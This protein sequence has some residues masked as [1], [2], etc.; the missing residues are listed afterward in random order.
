[1]KKLYLN[2][3]VIFL[4]FFALSCANKSQESLSSNQWHRVIELNLPAPSDA[5]LISKGMSSG[6]LLITPH[7][8]S[9]RSNQ[10]YYKIYKSL[11]KQEYKNSIPV[12]YNERVEH[13]IDLFRYRHHEQFSK[14][15]NRSQKYLPELTRLLE[16]Q[17]MPT[18]LAYLPLIESGY[19]PRARSPKNAV[20]LW[21]FIKSTGKIYDLR[22]DSW[23]DERKDIYKST[24]AATNYLKDLHDQFGSWEL[25]LAAYNCGELRVEDTINL[26][27]SND[28][29]HIASSLPRE[30]RNYVPKFIAA[31]IIAKNPNKYG[32]SRI[33]FEEPKEIIKVTVP[34]QKYL[35][36]IAKVIDYKP[37]ELKVLNLSLINGFTP[38]REYYDIYIPAEYKDEIASKSIEIAALKNAKIYKQ[39]KTIT[40]RVRSGDNL[41]YIAKRYGVSVSSIKKTNRLKSNLIRTGQKLRIPKYS[42]AKAYSYK[43]SK[44]QTTGT[45][46]YLVKSGDTL[47]EIAEKHGVGLSKLKRYNGLKSSKIRTGQVLSIPSGSSKKS[48]NYKV[49]RGDTLS[50]IA[51]KYRVS[52][53]DIKKWNNLK[54]TRVVTGK[55]LKI[56]R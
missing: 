53:A 9:W 31:K 25:A 6:F 39:P 11:L 7:S 21:Q 51:S 3:F 5:E 47:G 32:F 30:T 55:K 44:S 41:S 43:S 36:D 42:S 1:M 8:S 50:E 2:I 54:S 20:G 48:I 18:D 37:D 19:N 40:Y 35:S 24:F 14:W 15:L 4:L 12:T 10:Y 49:K 26:M 27:N 45:T 13:Y 22:I 52:I 17:E 16:E 46:K 34:P 38:P 33:K 56:Y 29:W 28:F 23:V